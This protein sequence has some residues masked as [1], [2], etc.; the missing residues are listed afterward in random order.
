MPQI[1]SR[2]EATPDTCGGKP[3][4]VGTRIRVQDVYVWHEMQGQ[5]PEEIVVHF[6]HLTLACVHSAIAYYLDHLDE[7]R[8]DLNAETEYVTRVKAEFELGP[9][10]AKLIHGDPPRAP[11]ST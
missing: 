2:I 8:G 1:E 11:L 10:A 5:T 9:L 4:I 6:P 3:R 7:I